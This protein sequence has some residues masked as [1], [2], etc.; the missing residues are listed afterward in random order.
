LSDDEVAQM[1]E[2]AKEYAKSSLSMDKMI[3]NAVSVVKK[4][5]VKS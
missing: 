5:V 1:G 3:D 4:W 2:R